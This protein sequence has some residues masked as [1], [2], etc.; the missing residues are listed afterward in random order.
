MTTALRS[1]P[2]PD[3]LPEIDHSVTADNIPPRREGV[4]TAAKYPNWCVQGTLALVV[5]E[6]H[7][8]D[9]H[10]EDDCRPVPTSS[11]DLPDPRAWGRSIV[12]VLL[13]VISGH[14]Q[15]AQLL[16]WTTIEVYDCIRTQ[17]LPPPRPGVPQV[18]RRPRVT[19]I[20]VYEPDDGVAEVSAIVV[21]QH[22]T[23]AIALRLEGADGRWVIT[24]YETG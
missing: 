10:D 11:R 5:G 19:S 17:I 13:E 7:L 8:A 16:R 3:V 2:V 22:R 15:T 18:R 6:S 1:I 9:P 14:R 20:H 4:R 24:A 12:Q 21:G 23:Q